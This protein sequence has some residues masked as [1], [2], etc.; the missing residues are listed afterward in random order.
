MAG[1]VLGARVPIILPAAPTRRWRGSAPARSR[2]CWRATQSGR[3]IMSDAILVL[4][5]GSS[6][7]K[8]ALFPGHEQP[9]RQGL[10]CD[11]EFEGIGHQVHFAARTAKAASSSTSICRRAKPMRTRSLICFAGSNAPSRRVKL[12]AAGHRVVHG[13]ALYTG[14]IRIDQSVIAELRRLMPLAPLHQPHHL[15][16]IAALSKLHPRCRR[17]PVSTPP[18]ITRSRRSP[19]SSP[20]PRI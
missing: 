9:T 1:I 13:G 12:I 8:F 3:Q 11:G 17:S 15:A 10:I 20:A 16:A 5:A 6:S 7:I 19:A 4:N 18:S 14:P 2:S